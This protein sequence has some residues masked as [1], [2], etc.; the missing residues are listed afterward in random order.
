MMTNA[1]L[2]FR[3]FLIV[4]FLS[5]CGGACPDNPPTNNEPVDLGGDA[6]VDADGTEDVGESDTGGE[7]MPPSRPDMR[8]DDDVFIADLGIPDQGEQDMGPIVLRVDAVIPP[9]GPVEGDTPIV[10]TGS[11]FT[12]ETVV[13]FGSRPV[14]VELIDGDL[15]G[16]S[17]PGQ[18][19]GP[20]AVKVLDPTYGEEVLPGGFEYISPLAI[21]SVS[22]NRVPTDGGVE[23]TIRGRGFDDDTRASF[24]GTTGLRHTLVDPTLMR[25]IV[26]A[27]AAGVFDVRVS[28]RDATDVHPGGIEYFAPLRVDSVRPATGPTAGGTTVTLEGTGFDAGLQV[29]FGGTSAT[30]QTVA[31]TGD[32]ATV[33]TPAHAAGLVSVRVENAAG[34][35]HIAPNAFYYAA[36]GEFSIAMLS[37]SQ[38]VAAGG[39]EV[40]ILGAGL[41]APGLSVRFDTSAATIVDQGPGHVLVQTPA[42]AV[43]AVD[44]TIA[45]GAT[46]DTLAGAFTYVDD[47]WIDRV[48]PAAGDVAGGFNVVIDGEGFTGATAV[49]FGGI[50]AAFTV[51]SDQMITAVAPAH[52][53]GVVDVVV[54]RDEVTARFRDAFTYTE[55]LEVFG[56][57]PVRGSVAGNTYVEIYGR[58]F[59]GNVTAAFD[60]I[61]SPDVQVLDSQTLAVRTPPHAS[62][63]VDVS[64]AAGG[65]TVSSPIPYTYFNP[66][67]RFG[68]A[69][70]GPVLGAVNVTVYSLEGQPLENAFVMLSTTPDTPYQGYT[71]VNGMVTLSGPDVYGEQTVTATYQLFIEARPCNPEIKWTS[72]A[73]VQRVDAENITIFLSL[74]P[75]PPMGGTPPPEDGC[76]EGTFEC[77]CRA[78]N[79]PCDDPL[80]C[81]PFT[82]VCCPPPPEFPEEPTA[83]YTGYLSGLDKLAEPGPTEFQMAIVYTTQT[84]PYSPNPNPGDGNIVLTNGNYTLTSRIGDL[85]LIAVGGLYNNSTNTFK[86][87]MMGVERYLFAADGQTYVVDLDLNIPL[88]TPLSFKLSHSPRYTNGPDMNQVVPWLDLGFE[89]VF[90]GVDLAEGNTDIVTAQHQAALTGIF[91]DA[92]YIA[93]GGAFRGGTVPMTIG[94]K[95]G[96]TDTANIIDIPG[97]IGIAQVTSPANGMVPTSGLIEFDLREPIAPD[98]FYVDISIPTLSGLKTL[99]NAFLPGEA[100][101]L[102]LPDFPSF[103]QLPPTNQPSPYPPGTY[104]LDIIA[105]DKPV[106][107]W[108]NFSYNDLAFGDWEAYS[109]S[110]TTVSF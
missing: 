42:H 44:V 90:G 22:P 58:G 28:N 98:F 8:P 51:D 74:D 48:T 14:N 45:D 108:E 12:T 100:R 53:A 9:R 29:E 109:Y 34:D 82:G 56:L 54:E 85:A 88:D 62:G 37:P 7:D 17:P 19:P 31:M 36:P 2:V 46:T 75:P 105:V 4:A 52:S 60:Q 3:I 97:L 86:P 79:P 67:S 59:V 64:V 5:A 33:V 101:S 10:I 43:G 78:G 103:T 66:G 38:G 13:Y 81:N 70:G 23:V 32:T 83:T 89:G 107:Q 30:V 11:G 49:E 92:S 106:F 99:W 72:S 96:I 24:G 50:P 41:D 73:T 87:L 76:M 71:D 77:W 84:D 104:I 61:A 20:V 40:L 25:V 39:T 27:H 91:S 63:I 69:W 47:L 94:I 18:G 65:Q 80:A 95:R 26:P 57:K 68:G 110:R 1:R 16:H 21:D 102:R 6:G 55:P 15:V 93:I 35:A